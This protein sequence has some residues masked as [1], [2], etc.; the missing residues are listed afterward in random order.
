M[1]SHT[2]EC[3]QRQILCEYC[4]SPVPIDNM[5]NHL[6]SCTTMGH[7]AAAKDD[8]DVDKLSAP[9]WKAGQKCPYGCKNLLT[10]CKS[11][12]THE[13]QYLLKHL[14]DIHSRLK[15]LELAS[16][17]ETAALIARNSDSNIEKQLSEEMEHNSEKKAIDD[18]AFTISATLPQPFTTTTSVQEDL[19][20]TAITLDSERFSGSNSSLSSSITSQMQPQLQP[21]SSG[22]ALTTT[23]TLL[24][25][26][27]ST[28]SLQDDLN[29]NAKRKLELCFQKS[30][31]YESMAMVLNVSLD[32][33][34]SQVQEINNQRQRE[35]ET[36]KA[37]QRKIQVGL[38]LI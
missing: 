8:F 11:F 1:A 36:L 2:S 18:T 33:L 19:N 27:K 22:Y 15:K 31:M 13:K 30:E 21:L 26:F 9:A 38:F 12:W 24:L 10:D 20:S 7:A 5:N 29:S 25:P 6:T 34:L 28:A 4:L 32:R 16:P 17:K 35:S 37:L 3:P 14:Q 23:E